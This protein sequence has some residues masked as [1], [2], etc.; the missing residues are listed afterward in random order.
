M[1]NRKS[2]MLAEIERELET[3]YLRFTYLWNFGLGFIYVPRDDWQFG[4]L[5]GP[6]CIF[7]GVQHF[8]YVDDDG[9]GEAGLKEAA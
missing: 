2:W 7:I 5:I 8:E 9:G 3:H 4:V 6:F 1:K